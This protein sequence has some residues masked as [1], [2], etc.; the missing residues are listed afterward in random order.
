MKH[1]KI[2]TII[3]FISFMTWFSLSA[4]Q[5]LGDDWRSSAIDY[6][7][8]ILYEYIPDGQTVQAELQTYPLSALNEANAGNLLKEESSDIDLLES[9][10]AVVSIGIDEILE[11]GTNAS[12]APYLIAK[13][14]TEKGE[15][16]LAASFVAQESVGRILLSFSA[17]QPSFT[18]FISSNFIA[19]LFQ[20]KI[21]LNPENLDTQ[22]A[23]GINETAIETETASAVQ[24]TEVNNAVS[25]PPIPTEIG[26][27]L[28][29]GE[30]EWQGWYKTTKGVWKINPNDR[31]S[32]R[33]HV[34]TVL[35][36]NAPSFEQSVR[37]LLKE[38]NVNNARAE[39]LEEIDVA[40]Q[41]FG[42]R[43][44]IT[45]G[46]SVLAGQEAKFFV[47]ITQ[48][49][50]SLD[51]SYVFME[52]P[53]EIF[54]VWGGSAVMLITTGIHDDASLRNPE[55][56]KAVGNATPKEQMNFFE[57]VY[58]LKAQQLFMGIVSTQA[59]TLL[60]MQELNFDL[61]FG[62]DM[63]TPFDGGE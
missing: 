37:Y 4:A 20:L 17:D 58:S 24:T 59:Q 38:L 54:S 12:G 43:Q 34:G 41:L 47:V 50:G 25:S 8:G 7:Q 57:Q 11:Q 46:S 19:D 48:I 5:T 42:K 16:Y 56:L 45:A 26:G 55:L 29:T 33:I 27:E 36:Q 63:A 51:L 53:S 18:D 13:A 61:L 23:Q 6:P 32:P 9:A 2:Y 44:F 10:L 1:F 39:A 49:E 60:G 21:S 30:N 40:V 3:L 35:A 31:A 52:A 14:Y 62:D 28:W 22:F 15:R